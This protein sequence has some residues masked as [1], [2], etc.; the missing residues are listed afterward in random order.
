MFDEFMPRVTADPV[1]KEYTGDNRPE[2]IRNRTD[3]DADT[4][5]QF[6]SELDDITAQAN[7]DYRQEQLKQRMIDEAQGRQYD[8]NSSRNIKNQQRQDELFEQQSEALLNKYSIPRTFTTDAGSVYRFNPQ[9]KYTKVFDAGMGLGDWVK[10]AVKTGITAAV[11]A[12]LTSFLTA[13]SGLGLSANTAKTV[14]AGLNAAATGGDPK[15]VLKAMVFQGLTNEAL[16]FVSNNTDFQKALNDLGASVGIGEQVSVSGVW[17]TLPDGTRVLTETLQTQGNLGDMLAKVADAIQNP[18]SWTPSSVEEVNIIWNLAGDALTS[19][20]AIVGENK[21]SVGGLLS[22]L[23][24]AK[25]V[26]DNANQTPPT[27]NNGLTM[28]I[29]PNSGQPII[30]DE[31]GNP[32]IN[33]PPPEDERK[34]KDDGGGGGQSEADKDAAAAEAKKDAAAAEAKKDAA[35]AEAKKDAEAAAE[36]KKDA[37]AAAEAKKDAETEAEKDKDNAEAEKDKDNYDPENPWIYRGNGVFEHVKTGEIRTEDVSEYDPY[38]IGD[39]YGKGPDP[40]E[41]QDSD[42]DGIPDNEDDDI[43]GDGY[44]NIL[45]FDPFDPNVWEDPDV[46]AERLE[47]EATETEKDKDAEEAEKEKDKAEETE[48]EKDKAEEAEKE[49]DAERVEK[50]NPENSLSPDELQAK[51]PENNLS[52]EEKQ[53]K[54]AENNLSPEEKQSKEAENNLTPD[55]LAAKDSENNL[56]P[57]ELQAKDPENS[58]TPDQLAAK[59]SENNLSPDQ[60]AS[61][62]PENN[63]SPDQLASKDPENNLTPEELQAKD[64]ENGL[65]ADQ[66][67][68]KDP[69]N[70]LSP[71]E[72]QSKEAENSL[73]PEEKQSKEAENSLSPEEKQAKEAENNLSPE[74]K[75]A[76]DGNGSGSGTGTGNGSGNGS[77][78]GTGSGSGRGMFTG[79]GGGSSFSPKSFMASISYDPQLLTPY[80]PQT[81]KDYLAELLARLQ[82]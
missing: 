45:D 26:Y 28:T 9:G 25:E 20:G 33:V 63:L 39:Y 50:E 41:L 14:V 60:L 3:I 38:V 12:G 5:N 80:M 76:K 16:D 64:P 10:I 52:P 32:I 66:K 19:G 51:D 61:K 78:N 58:L 24:T 7:L 69:E 62:D 36:A 4:Y 57:E 73:S 42:G 43:D 59:D 22:L 46:V 65:T 74:E 35:A 47:K 13:P 55:Q 75:Q 40:E 49:K 81:S 1:D 79:G 56:S 27:F 68:A 11:G 37:E 2:F 15:D 71:E 53:S 70:S 82:Q 6:L 48:K 23:R 29:D 30:L 67:Q 21:L 17:T 34:D 18:S 8:P 72:K 54:E 77:G 31:N 44:A